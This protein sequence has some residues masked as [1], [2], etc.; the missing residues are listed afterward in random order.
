[1]SLWI[2]YKSGINAIWILSLEAWKWQ[3]CFFVLQYL[4]SYA[5]VHTRQHIPLFSLN[6]MSNSVTY[7]RTSIQKSMYPLS[8]SIKWRLQP[9]DNPDNISLIKL[10]RL[11]HLP[12]WG[13]D[14]M[15]AISQTT[16]SSAFSLIKI[17][18][19]RLRFHWS[20]FLRVQLAIF[21]H[22]FR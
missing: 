21:Q 20:L 9:S 15:D 19:F 2:L 4:V 6:L 22:W 18:E 17:L 10:E 11:C 1:M 13:R 14:K 5:D 3:I 16:F 7:I 12:H 8:H